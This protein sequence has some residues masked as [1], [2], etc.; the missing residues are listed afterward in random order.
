MK[1]IRDFLYGVFSSCISGCRITSESSSPD[2]S[3]S[4]FLDSSRLEPTLLKARAGSSLSVNSRAG[5]CPGVI[6]MRRQVGF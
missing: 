2:S 6:D 4:S 5:S 1:M 3:G